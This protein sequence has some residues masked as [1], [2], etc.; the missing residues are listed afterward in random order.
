LLRVSAPSSLHALHL[1]LA[2]AISLAGKREHHPRNITFDSVVLHG[3]IPNDPARTDYADDSAKGKKAGAAGSRFPKM[4][5]FKLSRG[6]LIPF[7][8]K[9]LL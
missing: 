1:Y 7:E 5:E 4:Y 3:K 6:I 9:Q 2:A 8:W